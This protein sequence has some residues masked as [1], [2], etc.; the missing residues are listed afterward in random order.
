[1]A[2]ARTGGYIVS[3]LLAVTIWVAIAAAGFVFGLVGIGVTRRRL[4]AELHSARSAGTAPGAE[5]VSIL[6][7]AAQPE[8]AVAA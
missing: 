1:M 6:D 8:R 4:A 5:I 2:V 7:N 3:D